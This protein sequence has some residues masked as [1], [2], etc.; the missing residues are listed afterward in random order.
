MELELA[1]GTLMWLTSP[2]RGT[3]LPGRLSPF[4]MKTT[5]D[6]MSGPPDEILPHFGQPSPVNPMTWTVVGF[7]LFVAATAGILTALN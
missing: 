7:A 6:S 4:P 5:R 2:R 3:H 1:S